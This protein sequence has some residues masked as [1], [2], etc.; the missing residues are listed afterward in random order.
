MALLLKPSGES[1]T[2]S[3]YNYEEERPNIKPKSIA[4]HFNKHYVHHYFFFFLSTLFI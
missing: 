2:S 3:K 1:A 4:P